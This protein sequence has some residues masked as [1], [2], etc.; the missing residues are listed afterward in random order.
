MDKPLHP[1]NQDWQFG[2]WA[3]PLRRGIMNEEW[4]FVEEMESVVLQ[5]SLII[6][7]RQQRYLVLAK[8]NLSFATRIELLCIWV[9]DLLSG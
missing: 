3:V 4:I 2:H 9:G 7:R 5:G 8:P 6:L 1:L